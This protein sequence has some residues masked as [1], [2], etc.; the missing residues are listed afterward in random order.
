MSFRGSHVQID[1]LSHRYGTRRPWVLEDVSLT[2][3]PGTSVSLVGR[4][5][6]GKS[7]L[8]QLMS[9]LVSA[10][11]GRV[12]IDGTHVRSPSPRWNMMFQ[13]PSLY[14]WMS[15]EKNAALGML[16]AGHSYQAKERVP[17]LLELVG[18]AEFAKARVRQLSGGQQQR[19]ALARSLA[20]QPEL[21]ML[22][23]PFAA[24]DES[25]RSA[26]QRDVIRITQQLGIT[27][28]IVTHDIDEA[29]VMA[30]RVVV[31]T[32]N[33]GRIAADFT[34]EQ[35]QSLGLKETKQRVRSILE[36]THS[37]S[38][39]SENVPEQARPSVCSAGPVQVIEPEPS[40]ESNL[41][42]PSQRMIHVTTQ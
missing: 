33:P 35:R 9:G 16:I 29:F 23:E 7:T 1:N 17:E 25:T 28:V 18:M 32:P 41:Q 15:A 20:T 36:L 19:V 38:S 31:M 30:D 5:G 14:P 2:I 4:S 40:R 39:S 3:E 22:D 13:K 24:L 34:S 8:L 26:M 12:T 37:I 27:L 6:C 11:Q 42:A 21:L 10:T